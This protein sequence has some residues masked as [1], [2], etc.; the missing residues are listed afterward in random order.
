MAREQDVVP[1]VDRQCVR[2]VVVG[3]SVLEPPERRAVCCDL[4]DEG[5]VA[6]LRDGEQRAVRGAGDHD[7]VGAVDRYRAHD[8]VHVG[9]VLRRPCL[10]GVGHHVNRG[11]RVRTRIDCTR[12]RQTVDAEDAGR[13][14]ADRR[15]GAR[16]RATDRGPRHAHVGG[17]G[18][19]GGE[20]TA[21]I[22]HD[23]D[24]AGVD[25]DDHLFGCGHDMHGSRRGDARIRCA[26][27]RDLVVALDVVSGVRHFDARGVHDERATCRAPRHPGIAGPGHRGFEVHAR[28]R[29]HLHR[30]RLKRNAHRLALGRG[31]TRDKPEDQECHRG[32]RYDANT[33][34]PPPRGAPQRPLRGPWGCRVHVEPMEAMER[35]ATPTGDATDRAGGRVAPG[36]RC[37]G[38]RRPPPKLKRRR[39][40]RFER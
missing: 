33:H 21:P 24:V 5:V 37:L 30:R 25:G 27:G 17:P 38:P 26:S 7:V 29:R 1:A 12:G 13:R 15:A 22:Q 36:V 8:V 3:R 11:G 18:D 35:L 6:P 20:V 14:V 4:R 2:V 34:A 23:L 19:H 31:P 32:C 16:N 10:P 39:V 40:L 9:A 28:G